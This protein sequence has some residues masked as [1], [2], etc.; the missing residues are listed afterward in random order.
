MARQPSGASIGMT[1]TNY[2]GGAPLSQ[3]MGIK[4][5]QAINNSSVEEKESSP[6]LKQEPATDD[7]PLSSSE[8]EETKEEEEEIKKE[9]EQKDEME[10]LNKAGTTKRK[11]DGRDNPAPRAKSQKSNPPSSAPSDE[12]PHSSFNQRKPKKTNTYAAK[13]SSQTFGSSQDMYKP[14]RVFKE[15]KLK[16]S[17]PFI[18]PRTIEIK[19]PSNLHKVHTSDS[20]PAFRTPGGPS[21]SILKSLLSPASNS[22]E[23]QGSS[24]CIHASGSQSTFRMPAGPNG[25][26]IES[27]VSPASQFRESAVAPSSALTS[28]DVDFDFDIDDDDSSPL[29]SPS[30]EVALAMT[31]LADKEA[32]TLQMEPTV[33][34][35]TGQ[36]RCPNCDAPVDTDLLDEFLIQYG[37]RLRD[38]RLFCERH[39]AH[40]AEKE[41]TDNGYPMI[42]WHTFDERLQ[43]HLSALERLLVPSPSSFYRGLLETAMK[44]GQAR[45]FKLSLEED[46]LENL[47]CGYYGP[48][49]ASRM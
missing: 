32:V 12:N 4:I 42:D 14:P 6:N 29:S 49:G 1:R 5:K 9:E 43:R 45:V 48:K 38:E 46:G 20:E 11:R 8:D 13:S 34:D 36:S 22:Q 39:K 18:T 2:T 3:V 44:D 16:S 28:A 37:R 10:T 47:S 25:S 41:W 19:D 24:T 17:A 26:V 27:L 15:N 40:K 30:S 35:T 31:E 21:D 33:T 23:E 7:E